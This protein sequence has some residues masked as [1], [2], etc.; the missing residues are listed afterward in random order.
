MMN[1]IARYLAAIVFL[2]FPAIA[3][4]QSAGQVECPRSG[5]YVYLYSSM[6]TLDVRTTLQC[7]EQVQITG[8]YDLYFGVRTAKGE[9]GYV[10]VEGLL[11]LKDKPGASAPQAKAVQP[12]RERMLYDAPAATEAAPSAAADP[13]VMTL[14][15]GTPIHLKLEKTMSS[16][17][18]HA[19]DVVELRVSE[20]VMVD[21]LLV[22]PSGAEA[23]GV[24]TEAETRKRLGHGGKLAFS[25]N[26]VQLKNNEK[27][28]VRSFQENSGANNAA[29]AILP[30]TS[31]KDVVYAQGADY[32]AYVDCDRKLKKES[33]STSTEKDS[34]SA[35][36][37]NVA[38]KPSRPRGL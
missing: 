11:L 18:A 13:N 6:V 2:T 25:I 3:E 17:T 38:P 16:A 36:P 12:N 14:R 32:T 21:G 28:A 27:A 34:S 31:G 29:C 22:I 35:V 23:T 9:V 8:R 20:N 19:G 7:G 33:F 26:S 15:N 4:A 24:V 5:G 10:P 30:L 1:S 37:A